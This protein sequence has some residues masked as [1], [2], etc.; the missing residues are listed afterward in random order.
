MTQSTQPRAKSLTEAF[1]G[2]Q[3]GSHKAA[4]AEQAQ[5]VAKARADRAVSLS[6]LVSMLCILGMLAGVVGTVL[7]LAA[8]IDFTLGRIW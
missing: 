4:L 8:L 5:R 6:S 1:L 2:P 7:G 3:D